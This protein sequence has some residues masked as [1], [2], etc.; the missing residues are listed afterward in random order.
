VDLVRRLLLRK[1]TEHRRRNISCLISS[2]SVLAKVEGT[3]MQEQKKDPTLF[4]I[5]PILAAAH[6]KHL[7]KV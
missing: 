4:P 1:I 6:E 5:D 7:K 2:I 3:L